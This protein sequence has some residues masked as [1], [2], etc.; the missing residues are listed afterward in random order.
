VATNGSKLP[1]SASA[2]SLDQVKSILSSVEA[3]A[4]QRGVPPNV[5]SGVTAQLRSALAGKFPQPTEFSLEPRAMS[6]LIVSGHQKGSSQG[7]IA[8]DLRK[9][10]QQ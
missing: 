10:Y 9:R 4:I 1:K 7:S 5:A 3:D 8:T 2:S 6:D